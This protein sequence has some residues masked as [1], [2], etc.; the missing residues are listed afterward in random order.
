[1]QKKTEEVR[2]LDEKTRKNHID[3]VGKNKC[4]V[5]LTP[6]YSGI[7]HN[8]DRMGNSCVNLVDMAQ[9]GISFRM[10]LDDGS[11]MGENR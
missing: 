8:I 2:R 11:D 7:L 6:L 3:R 1:M 4:N 9:G 10:L 5:K